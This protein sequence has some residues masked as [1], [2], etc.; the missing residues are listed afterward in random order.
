LRW[1]GATAAR[2]LFAMA[3]DKGDDGCGVMSRGRHAPSPGREIDHWFTT[4]QASE[5]EQLKR[6][7]SEEASY[8]FI[9]Y[10]CGD[11]YSL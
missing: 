3:G 10:Q 4:E 8:F 11:A 5:E 6:Q 9:A 1:G 2:D 7:V